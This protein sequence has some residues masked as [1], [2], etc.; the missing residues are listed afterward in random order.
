MMT[1]NVYYFIRKGKVRGDIFFGM[2]SKASS[3]A[4]IGTINGQISK[5]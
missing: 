2:H 1:S 4:Y 3:Y 5:I